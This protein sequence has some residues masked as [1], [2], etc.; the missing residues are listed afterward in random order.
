MIKY[1]I[2]IDPDLHKS[3]LA[4][5]SRTKKQHNYIDSV[6]AFELIQLLNLIKPGEALFFVDAGWLNGGYFHYANFPPEFDTWHVNAQYAY[7]V[8][9]GI[10][11][12]ENFGVGKFI[13]AYLIDVHGENNVRLVRPVNEKWDATKLKQLTG[14]SKRTNPDSRDAARLCWQRI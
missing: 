11:V 10:N 8:K 2:G 14:W 9:R 1:A 7:L 4:V 5:W 6:G 13:V 3:G 12:G